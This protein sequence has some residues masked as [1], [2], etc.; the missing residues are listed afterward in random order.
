VILPSGKVTLN[1]PQW[2]EQFSLA[3]VPLVGYKTPY[4]LT[5]GETPRWILTIL[6]GLSLILFFFDLTLRRLKRN[7]FSTGSST[8]TKNTNTKKKAG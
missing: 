5:V 7:S 8:E 2:S 1:L 6:V 3:Q 4:T